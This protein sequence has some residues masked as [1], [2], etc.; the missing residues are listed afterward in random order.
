MQ[1]SVDLPANITEA[2][3]QQPRHEG[4]TA[5]A[6]LFEDLH[7]DEDLLLPGR[8]EAFDDEERDESM[9]Q[10]STLVGSDAVDFNA[11]NEPPGTW[12]QMLDEYCMAQYSASPI[13]NIISDRRGGRTAWSCVLSV[14]GHTFAA[15]Y[16]YDGH[17]MHN[18]K[19]DAAEVAL[20]ILNP[21][22]KADYSAFVTAPAGDEKDSENSTRNSLSSSLKDSTSSSAIDVSSQSR[23]SQRTQRTYPSSSIDI[24]SK[25]EVEIV[26]SPGKWVHWCVDATKTRLHE[27]CVE[28][29]T[30]AKRGREFINELIDS[31]RRLR[32]IRWWLSLTDCA[33]VKVVKV[34]ELQEHL[35]PSSD[36]LVVYPPPG[37]RGSREMWAR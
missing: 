2:F 32:G 6:S 23:R 27:I 16:W 9:S 22:P 7:F 25:P 21:I 36:C 29:Q 5:G 28:A 11:L 4:M 37:R 13:Y 3:S 19:E 14:A 20:R 33:A 15:R 35:S 24:L 18:A 10:C 30:G 12:Q 17:Y 34:G 1:L 26:D 8:D 31:Y